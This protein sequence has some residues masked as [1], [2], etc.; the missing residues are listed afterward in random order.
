MIFNT[1]SQKQIDEINSNLRDYDLSKTTLPS[2][3]EFKDMIQMLVN[4][5]FLKQSNIIIKNGVLQ[6]EITFNTQLSSNTSRYSQGSSSYDITTL[7]TGSG[8]KTSNIVNEGYTKLLVE[9]SCTSTNTRYI[10]VNGAYGQGVTIPNSRSFIEFDVSSLSSFS[11]AVS[12]WNVEN[13]ISIY[14]AYL[15]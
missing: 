2:D 6:N 1:V 8:L 11:I 10:N 3:I 5:V 13:N 9:I 12:G 14:N 7:G 4:K 15:Q